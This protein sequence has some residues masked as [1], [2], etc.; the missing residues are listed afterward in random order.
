MSKAPGLVDLLQSAMEASGIGTYAWEYDVAAF[1]ASAR[2]HYTP[3]LVDYAYF[4]G[5]DCERK[6]TP[7]ACNGPALAALAPGQGA[8]LPRR[9]IEKLA[10]IGAS[11]IRRWALPAARQRDLESERS[12]KPSPTR[13]AT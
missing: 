1:T 3:L 8:L 10:F 4:D 12:P 7:A 5:G 6:P 9:H 11:C 2:C 13:S